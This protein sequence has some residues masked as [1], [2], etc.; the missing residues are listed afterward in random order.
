MSASAAA[1]A[2]AVTCRLA[3]LCDPSDGSSVLQLLQA[4]AMDPLG[5]G[6]GLGAEASRSL[7]GRLRSI[8]TASA[9]FALCEG[10]PVGMAL[11]F[12]SFSS[13]EAK[14]V[15]NIHDFVV[16]PGEVLRREQGREGG[17]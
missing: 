10:T 4:Y 11:C 14:R 15:L 3:D 12:D 13:F 8:G 7:L 9:F 6:E 1:A 5:G 17:C 16:L 2:A